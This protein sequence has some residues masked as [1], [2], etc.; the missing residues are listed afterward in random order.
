[1]KK[2]W[3]SDAF[4]KKLKEVTPYFL[5][6]GMVIAVGLYVLVGAYTIRYIEARKVTM[7]EDG[8]LLKVQRHNSTSSLRNSRSSDAKSFSK[9]KT[10]MLRTRRC[11]LNAVKRIT[12]EAKCTK[13]S[14]NPD[15]LYYLDKCYE[16]DLRELNRRTVDQKPSGFYSGQGDEW[17][18]WSLTD[19]VLFCFTVITTIGYGNVAPRTTEG[20]LF[21]IFYGLI[22]VPFTMLVIANLGKFLAEL[23]RRWTRMFSIFFRR[24]YFRLFKTRGVRSK[25]KLLEVTMNNNHNNLI[26]KDEPEPVSEEEGLSQGA[27]SLFVSFI[28]YILVG[29]FLISSYEPEMDWFKAIYFNF[30]T[31]TTI[32]LGDLVPRSENYLLFT[33]MYVAVG[34]ALTTIAIE[35]AADY[36]KKL[37]YFGR[38]ME[39]VSN[40][41]IWFG[42]KKL[43]M[44]QLVKNLGDQFNLPVEDLN[45]LNLDSFVDNAIRVEAGEIPSLRTNKRKPIYITDFK[46]AYKDGA[47]IFADEDERVIVYNYTNNRPPPARNLAKRSLP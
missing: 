16:S 21:V 7:R 31:L 3:K 13:E 23:L 12:K 2:F 5:H 27:L 8:F 28:L 47:V 10:T 42:S 9:Q 39:N 44:K 35:I 32:G 37:H 6:A 20:R 34:L 14:L 43:T 36:L 30:V 25:T 26:S 22:G 24:I 41:Q 18:Y 29:S 15:L 45:E 38:K 19:S 40:V 1:M 46:D 33:L 4:K 11:V 17:E